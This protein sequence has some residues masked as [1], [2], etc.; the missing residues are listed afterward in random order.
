[1]HNLYSFVV[2]LSVIDRILRVCGGCLDSHKASVIE[3]TVFICSWTKN[4][5]I[6]L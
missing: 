1:M 6:F 5:S 4:E 2:A 3:I